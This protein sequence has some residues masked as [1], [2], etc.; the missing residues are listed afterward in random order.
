MEKKARPFIGV[1]FKCCN[2]YA[3]IYLNRLG[4]AYFGHC[5]RCTR[6]LTVKVAKG[7]SRA[8]FWQAE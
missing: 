1:H 3:R 8:R 5:P 2:V 7:G 6:S 4:T